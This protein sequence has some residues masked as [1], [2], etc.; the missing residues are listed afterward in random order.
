MNSA[1]QLP[2]RNPAPQ[3]PSQKGVDLLSTELVTKANAIA[4][5]Q[6][7]IPTDRGAL[8]E[9]P[10]NVTSNAAFFLPVLFFPDRNGFALPSLS[11]PIFSTMQTKTDDNDR[12]IYPVRVIREMNTS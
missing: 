1:A 4:I 3:E 7:S 6:I 8:N 11:P 9:S 10:V 2:N 5:P 12:L